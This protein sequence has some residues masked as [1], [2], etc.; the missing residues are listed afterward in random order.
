[1]RMRR[2]A[3]LGTVR[4]ARLMKIEEVTERLYEDRW[5]W[6][7]VISSYQGGFKKI[8]VI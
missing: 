5:F 7:M 1:M 4:P 3:R 2:A 8:F 6:K